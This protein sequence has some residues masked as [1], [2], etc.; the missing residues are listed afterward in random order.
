MSLGAPAIQAIKPVFMMSPLSVAQYLD[1]DAIGF[2]MMVMD[3]ASQIEPVDALGAMARAQQIVIVGDDRQMP[4]TAFFKAMTAR[5][6]AARRPTWHGPRT[7]RA[8]SLCA[9]PAACRARCCAGTTA[10]ATRA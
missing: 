5:T 6:T 3:E 4:P 1:A 10:A 7:W 2:D 8:S 9:T